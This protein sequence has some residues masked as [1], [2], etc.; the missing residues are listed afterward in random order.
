MVFLNRRPMIDDRWSYAQRRVVIGAMRA[1]CLIYYPQKNTTQ[2]TPFDSDPT[3]RAVPDADVLGTPLYLG[4]CRVQ[5]N[6]DWRARRMEVGGEIV[7]D[8][9]VR[10]QID[11]TGNE[12]VPDGITPVI[13]EHALVRV[14]P[15][16]VLT[17]GGL[18]V[19]NQIGLVDYFVRIVSESS[20]S[21]VKTLLCDMSPVPNKAL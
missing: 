1:K 3:K 12:L 14:A 4:R 16:G 9:A 21:W 5:P 17:V 7:T 19:S 10:I 8:H 13:P 20:N 18:P 15:E 6:K 2:W 11:F